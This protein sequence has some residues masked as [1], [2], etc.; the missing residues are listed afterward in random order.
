[1]VDLI[2]ASRPFEQM[3]VTANLTGLDLLEI[4]EANVPEPGEKAKLDR[5]VQVSGMSYSVDR[6]R[7]KGSRIVA[8]DLV[9]QRLYKVVLEGQVPE[10]ESI[11]LAGRFG[12]LSY[13]STETPFLGA[14]YAHA[15][16]EG[17]V[18]AP[19]PGRL[20]EVVPDE[21]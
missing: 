18:S 8:H 17:R 5:V 10:R 20:R 12:T 15:V 2:Q 3:L 19:A 21:K 6:R 13:R 14:L 7:P 9:P 1:M 11:A 16:A 4:L